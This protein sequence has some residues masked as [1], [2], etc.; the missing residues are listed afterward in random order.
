MLLRSG[1]EV[2]TLTDRGGGSIHALAVGFRS[3]IHT[4]YSA[5]GCRVLK[6]LGHQGLCILGS[7]SWTRVLCIGGRYSRPN[8][9]GNDA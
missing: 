2:Y 3:G 9:L 8:E 7:I 5:E 4:T 1:I 6:L